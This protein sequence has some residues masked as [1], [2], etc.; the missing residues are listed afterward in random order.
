MIGLHQPC[1]APGVRR[2]ASEV[3]LGLQSQGRGAMTVG[4]AIPNVY[5]M[6]RTGASDHQTL[7]NQSNTRNF[8]ISLIHIA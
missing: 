5:H 2:V 1:L 6:A 7:S 8:L 4:Q 3:K